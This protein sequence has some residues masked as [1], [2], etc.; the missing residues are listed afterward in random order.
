MEYGRVDG[1]DSSESI[2]KAKPN[3]AHA[4]AFTSEKYEETFIFGGFVRETTCLD[5]GG[6]GGAAFGA[7]LDSSFFIVSFSFCFFLLCFIFESVSKI[8]KNH[9]IKLTNQKVQNKFI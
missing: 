4:T 8:C 7:S 6:T 3:D 5:G 1:D 2:E 9:Y